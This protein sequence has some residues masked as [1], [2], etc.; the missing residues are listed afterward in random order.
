M[1]WRE[2]TFTSCINA[3][4]FIPRSDTSM[5]Q[6]VKHQIQS[7]GVVSI[8]DVSKLYG[9]K[10]A[11]DRVNIQVHQGE[12][13]GLL[14]P[15]GAGKTT[16]L[17]ILEGLQKPS[18]GLV[19]LFGKNP[20]EL[21]PRER[22]RI[23]IVFQR[24]ALPAEL[25]VAQLC[26]LYHGMYPAEPDRKGLIEHLG[27]GH[28]L[29][30]QVGDLS[31]GQTQRL[32]IFAAL[33]GDK[34]LVVL[35]EPTSALDVRSRRAVWD[36]LLMRKQQGRFSG[37]IATHHMEEATELCDRI[38]F[39]DNGKIR[40]SGR[41]QDLLEQHACRISIKFSAPPTFVEEL[42]ASLPAD[43]Q[44]TPH[45]QQHMISCASSEAAALIGTLL[46]LEKKNELRINLMVTQPSLEDVY[47]SV[48]AN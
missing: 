3:H 33:Y 13:I 28:L 6:R 2:V 31:A 15:N 7:L 34:S 38:Y 32:S 36:A 9:E 14:G 44:L 12:V 26:D 41:A 46:L 29:Q 30:Q 21:N 43:A 48:I 16:L 5:D 37:I 25:T 10:L 47:L 19:S 35:D 42:R 45:G 4:H 17:E 40:M 18:S 20:A 24:Y 23:G 1:N 11:L 22:G 27:L 8:V 39:I